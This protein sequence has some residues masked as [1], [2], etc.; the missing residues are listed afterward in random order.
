MDMGQQKLHI[1]SHSFPNAFQ[2]YD[3]IFVRDHA[4]A[5][6]TQFDVEVLVPTPYAI[7]FTAKQHKNRAP[8][9]SPDNINADRIRYFSLPSKILPSLIRSSLSKKLTS[10]LQK[11]KPHL[12]HIHFLYSSGLAIPALKN[13]FN[14][15]LVL[16]IHGVD[17]YHTIKKTKLRKLLLE[18]LHSA[19]AIIAVGPKLREDILAQ[20]PELDAKLHTIHNYVDTSYFSPVSNDSKQNLK[21]ELGLSSDRF[22]LLSV[23]N[24]RYKKGIDLLVEALSMANERTEIDLHLIG[25]RNEEPNFEAAVLS[26]IKKKGIQNF[27][28]HG[29]EPRSSIQKWMQAVDGFI[30]PSRNEP[31]GISLIEAMACGLPVIS[32][33]SGGPEIILSGD[34]GILVSKENPK[35]LSDAI[36]K[37]VAKPEVNLKEQLQFTQD[38]FGMESYI[39]AHIKL[40]KNLFV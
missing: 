11:K 12:I 20:F 25:R 38:N 24:F 16:T 18:S 37:M 13:A 14:C 15:P 10:C 23:A 30:L 29:P 33:K 36:V 17:F 21:K 28:I 39:K 1:I 9:C 35:A 7:P 5:I 6:S 27:H 40:Y 22:Q 4:S 31:F 34:H 3:G 32:T 2:P 8:L 26:S 19:D